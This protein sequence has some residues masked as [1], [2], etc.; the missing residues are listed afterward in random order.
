[1]SIHV[2][3]NSNFQVGEKNYLQI[4]DE[5]ISRF[6]NRKDIFLLKF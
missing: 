5:W 4:D 6:Q 1:M 2:V 3:D